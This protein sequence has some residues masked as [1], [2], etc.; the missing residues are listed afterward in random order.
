MEPSLRQI[1]FEGAL[2]TEGKACTNWCFCSD[3]A[4]LSACDV[5]L[6][7]MPRPWKSGSIDQPIS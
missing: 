6:P 4:S 1:A 7:A 5:A 2:S 3:L